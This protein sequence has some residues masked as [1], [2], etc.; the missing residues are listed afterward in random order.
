MASNFKGRVLA[1]VAGIA[2]GKTKSYREVTVLAGRPLAYRAVGN[3]M[4]RNRNPK[5]PCHRVIRSDGNPGEYV[6]GS[7]AKIKILLKEVKEGMERRR[8]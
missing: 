3:I 1:V 5:I 6:R 7:R 8:G 2:R 4:A